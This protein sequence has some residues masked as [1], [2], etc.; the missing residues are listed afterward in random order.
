MTLQRFIDYI[1]M[2]KEADPA[3]R[4]YDLLH[5]AG[6]ARLSNALR[7]AGYDRRASLGA[8]A[9]YA[10]LSARGVELPVQDLPRMLQEWYQWERITSGKLTRWSFRPGQGPAR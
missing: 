4:A 9:L 8:P 2:D 5:C 3:Y 1:E 6:P 10:D 7:F